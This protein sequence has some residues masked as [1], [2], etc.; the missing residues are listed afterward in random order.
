MI[1]P[2]CG[3]VKF[4]DEL[5]GGD[6]AS[7][8]EAS[9]SER[10]ISAPD[11]Q[12]I[13]NNQEL[14][15]ALFT[16]AED[17]GDIGIVKGAITPH[18]LV[19]GNIPATLFKYLGKQ[20]PSVIVIFGPDHYQAGG[21][22][23]VSAVADWAT[24]FGKVQV[25]E[26]ILQ[27]LY[28][29][30]VAKD[31][32]NA[33]TNEHSIG[34]LVSF[35]AKFCPDSKIVPIIF[36]YTA[37][38]S[39]VDEFLQKL[40]PL[41]PDD[42]VFVASIDFSHYQNPTMAE[43]HDELNRAV[44]HN[45]E[46]NRFQNMEIDSTPSLYALLK[47]TE[48]FKTQKIA[49]EISGSSDKRMNNP[50]IE[51]STSYYAPFFVSGEKSEDRLSSMLFFG[52]LMLDRNVKV[53]IDK[54]GPDYIFT[55]LAGQE[56]RFF[57]GTDV[58]HANLEGPFADSRRTTSKEIAFRFDPMLISTLKKYRFNVFSQANNHSLDMSSAG[59]T[60]S[61]KNL[62]TANVG[63]YGSQYRIDND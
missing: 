24:P 13:P 59:F 34:A 54:N 46:Y 52:D 27:K 58:V 12:A 29:A 16:Q 45:F 5:S 28:E 25:D 26:N 18:H 11:L 32:Y 38:T 4:N 44:I 17:I 51:E 63:V 40:W 36:P 35:I 30:N 20:K 57:M 61:L 6:S 50:A 31:N 8:D 33:F 53:Q 2:G 3:S 7:A 22:P 10:V 62:K 15:D 56:N 48:L 1:L 21:A 23:V 49:Y 42:A 41:L 47:S 60:E 14:Y 55:K 39:T 19:G 9:N 43:F 37:P